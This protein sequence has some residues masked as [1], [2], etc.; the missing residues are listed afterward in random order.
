MQGML[1][2]SP[3]PR[4]APQVS[5]QHLHSH[6]EFLLRVHVA[7]AGLMDGARPVLLPGHLQM[8]RPDVYHFTVGASGEG[9]ARAGDEIQVALMKWSEGACISDDKNEC[10]AEMGVAWKQ[11]DSSKLELAAAPVRARQQEG[12][13]CPHVF[14]SAGAHDGGDMFDLLAVGSSGDSKKWLS[15]SPSDRAW[16]WWKNLTVNI[17]TDVKPRDFCVIAIEA[18]PHMTSVLE[19]AAGVV[20]GGCRGVEV[21]AGTAAW[22]EDGSIDLNLDTR[23][24]ETGLS[25]SLLGGHP[26]AKGSRVTVKSISTPNL[27]RTARKR[28]GENGL[29]V[30][31]MDIEGAEYEVLRAMIADGS[32][33]SSVDYLFVEWHAM[34]LGDGSDAPPSD[35]ERVFEWISSVKGC[36]TRVFGGLY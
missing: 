7:G 25:S 6:G 16:A 33:C 9:A 14:I 4:V 5:V 10:G 31:K 12:R 1:S 21:M 3:F 19:K 17:A 34:A 13:E 2:T 23:Q 36:R 20:R 35:F 8:P 22:V 11:V 15:D 29:V 30:L 18:N 26:S 32:L 28:T 24:E 27:V